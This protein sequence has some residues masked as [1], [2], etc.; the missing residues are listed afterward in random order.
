MASSK[1]SVQELEQEKTRKIME[2][3]AWK[4]AYFRSNPQRF[5]S[6]V[7]FAGTNFR[8]RLFQKIL[9]YAMIHNNF[10]MYLAARGQ[11]GGQ[12]S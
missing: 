3:V 1:K 10:I 6:E 7:L 12:Y 4:A 9:L 5:V 2:I 11:G 8:L